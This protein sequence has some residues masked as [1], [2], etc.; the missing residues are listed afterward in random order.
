LEKALARRLEPAGGAREECNQAEAVR[1]ALA[2]YGD[3]IGLA[4]DSG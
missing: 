4:V 3:A 2:R 1:T